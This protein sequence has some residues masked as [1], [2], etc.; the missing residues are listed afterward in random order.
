MA[1]ALIVVDMQNDFCPGGSLAVPQGDEVVPVLNDYMQRAATAGIPIFASRDWHPAHTAHFRD[2]GGPW[3]PH[4]VQQTHGAE[5]HPELAL[6]EGAI[7][8]SK[9]MDTRDD[10]YS[11]LEALLPDGRDLLTAL[12]D[13]GITTVHVGGLATDYCVS[14]TA[15]GARAAGLRVYFLEDAIRPVDVQPGDGKRAI[16]EMLT[17]GARP[18][19]LADVRFEHE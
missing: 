1:D 13:A 9:G 11:A 10:G 7:V 6:P 16:Q 3:P 18:E 5:F 19:T 12:R 2:E 4:C 14:A 17:A 15:L 8:V